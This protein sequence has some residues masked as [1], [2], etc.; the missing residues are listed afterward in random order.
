MNYKNIVVLYNPSSN[1]GECEK[2]FNTSINPILQRHFSD[3]NIKIIQTKKGETIK[4]AESIISSK[5]DLFIVIGGDGTFSEVINAKDADNTK[6]IFIPCGTGNDFVR[7]IGW[8]NGYSDD[9]LYEFLT[10]AK[11]KK[12][13]IGYVKWGDNV[14]YFLNEVSIGVSVD[15]MKRIKSQNNLWFGRLSFG[16]HALAAYYNYVYPSLTIKDGY[17]KFSGEYTLLSVS[18]GKY[19]GNGMKI[20]PNAEINDGILNVCR[21]AKLSNLTMIS[22]L[23]SVST[24]KEINSPLVDYT[25]TKH[26]HIDSNEELDDIYFEVDGDIVGY[27][28]C[29]IYVLQSAINVFSL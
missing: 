25:T 24:G 22:M 1:N 4:Q 10:N 14:R 9:K 11:P 3:N 28:P 12:I 21:A 19:F 13:D 8:E 2:V 15:T 16:Y 29:D 23:W 7:N 20:Q 6:F 17:D 18:N 5:C 27:L 26:I